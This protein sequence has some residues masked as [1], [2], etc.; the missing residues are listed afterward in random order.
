MRECEFE[1]EGDFGALALIQMGD[2]SEES[3]PCL[4]IDEVSYFHWVS[5]CHSSSSCCRLAETGISSRRL[6]R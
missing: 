5:I 4:E 6:T 3:T 2:Q 1:F